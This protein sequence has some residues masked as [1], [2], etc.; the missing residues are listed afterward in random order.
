MSSILI[1]NARVVN[2]GRIS[3]KD[4]LTRDDIIVS[5]GD[6]SDWKRERLPSMQKD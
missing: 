4:L 6:S 1:R 2:E 3:K 5:L